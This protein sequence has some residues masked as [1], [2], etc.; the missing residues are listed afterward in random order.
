VNDSLDTWFERE[1]LVHEA[2][3]VRYLRHMWRRRDDIHDLRQDIYIRVYEAAAK[4]RPTSPKSF[5]FSTARHLMADHVRRRRVVSI[6]TMGD[7]EALNV[8]VD[9]LSPEERLHARQELRRFAKAL[10]LLPP[11]CREV[12]WMRRVDE[13]PQQEVA[14]RLGIS[15]KT[16]E[17]HVMKGMRLLADALFG[18]TLN[19]GAR[20]PVEGSANGSERGKQPRN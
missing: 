14:T 13:L 19:A 12:V 8:L 18:S 17:K 6:D 4:A 20:E 15:Q 2:A 9:D 3:L 16:V 1:I 11:K 10:D 7:L 5:L